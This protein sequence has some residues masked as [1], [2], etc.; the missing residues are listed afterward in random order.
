MKKVTNG[1]ILLVVL[2][3]VGFVIGGI[4]LPSQFERESS[5][6]LTGSPDKLFRCLSNVES[7]KPLVGYTGL[8][9]QTFTVGDNKQ[10]KTAT[11]VVDTPYVSGNL[12]YNAFKP[13]TQLSVV[14]DGE[15]GQS[16]IVWTIGNSPSGTVV[17]TTV[18][19]APPGPPFVRNWQVLMQ[20]TTYKY[21]YDYA[22]CL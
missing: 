18:R 10:G 2:A 13:N 1:L 22:H 7:I 4:F 3:A 14:I 21:A 19:F 5:T 12:R 17:D 6:A 16:E 20:G 15:K 9:G 8:P 11:A